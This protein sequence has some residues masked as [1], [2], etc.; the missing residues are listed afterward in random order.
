MSILKELKD[1]NEGTSSEIDIKNYI[2][3]HPDEIEN[4]SARELGKLT[5]TSAASVTRFCTKL[6]YK[7][8]PDFKLKFVSEL[9][10]VDEKN[11][12]ENLKIAAKENVVTMMKKITEIQKKAVKE[13]GEALSFEKMNRIRKL[14]HQC[15]ILDFYA[16]DVNVHLAHYASSQFL[17]AGKKSTV[18][19]ATN[20]QTLNALI[21]N[22]KNTAIV[23][24]QTGENSR[25]V[26]L[27]KILKHNNTKVIVITPSSKSTLGSMA[28]EHLYAAT[29][30]NF[31][32]FLTPAFF[33]SVKY[34]LDIFWGLEFSYDFDKN[35]QLNH[36]YEV[37][38]E[39]HFWGLLKKIIDVNDSEE[40]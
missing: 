20:M 31:L 27:V 14:I 36:D 28:D 1:F 8:Y 21:S 34:L 39:A 3:E 23:I 33:S 40:K 22:E 6:G 11:T 7:G 15:E 35:S 30:K 9:K 19:T 10:F 32:A 4:L 13:T 37:K 12:G 38:G 26:E 5:F 18:H 25:L 29:T 2:L 17:F 24:S 16:Y